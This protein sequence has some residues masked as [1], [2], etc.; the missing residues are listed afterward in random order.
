[1]VAYRLRYAP[2]AGTYRPQEVLLQGDDEL[3]CAGYESPMLAS[4]GGNHL[5]AAL[6]GLRPATMYRVAVQAQ[7][8]SGNWGPYSAD[9]FPATA[10]E[11]DQVEGGALHLIGAGHDYLRVRW[12][13]PVV[14]ASHINRYE[15]SGWSGTRS[16]CGL[17]EKDR[18]LARV[19]SARLWNQMKR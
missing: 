11:I 15:V 12:S 16:E 6:T 14:V 10:P 2:S 5:C 1:M 13:P 3:S 17:S 4:G 9:I 8:S 19:N 18:L 7:A